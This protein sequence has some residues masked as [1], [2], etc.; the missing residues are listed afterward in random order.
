[1][2]ATER[3]LR[4][5]A[6][7]RIAGPLV[8]LLLVLVLAAGVLYVAMH[9]EAGAGAITE[10]MGELWLV[11]AFALLAAAMRLTSPRPSAHARRPRG[12]APPGADVRPAAPAADSYVSPLR[13]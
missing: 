4:R 7:H 11:A 13:N 6:R 9:D 8:I 2:I 1:M 5:L 3:A 12:R 10:L